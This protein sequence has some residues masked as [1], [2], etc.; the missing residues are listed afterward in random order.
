MQY[1]FYHK[2]TDK[3]VTIMGGY[4]DISLVA[5]ENFYK[6]LRSNSKQDET[7]TY[8]KYFSTKFLYKNFKNKPETL[9]TLVNIFTDGGTL[10]VTPS[11]LVKLSKISVGDEML[12]M[13]LSSGHT[14]EQIL[15]TIDIPA[16]WSDR[17]FS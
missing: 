1:S 4:S 14:Y 6:Y 10:N 7:L 9:E 12:K 16:T 2:Q 17:L 15:E 11:E 8:K 3:W 5:A 13:K